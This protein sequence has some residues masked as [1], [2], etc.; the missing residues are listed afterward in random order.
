MTK[1]LM[2][3]QDF[4]QVKNVSMQFEVSDGI[5]DVLKDVNFSVKKN[6][7]TVLFGPSGS[8][9]TTILNILLGLLPP[10]TGTV[11]VAGHRLYDMNQNERAHF[12]GENYGLVSQT[13]TWVTSLNVVENI[14]LPLYLKGVDSDTAHKQ[15]LE[16]LERVGLTQYASYHPSVLSIG[17]QQR[18]GMARATVEA[19]MLLIADEPTGNLDS[20]NGD[21]IMRLITSFKNHQDATIILV[22]H[23]PDYLSLSDHR[24]FIK[25]GTLSVNEG[26]FSIEENHAEL[27]ASIPQSKLKVATPKVPVGGKK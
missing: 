14:A 20:R 17:Q 6:S 9:K 11:T 22:T 15:A 3:T 27:S 18:I 1:V 25:D 7:F 24:L 10:T 13:I 19:P 5:V 23:N 26:G 2:D 16:S 12:R 4:I 21:M 8:G